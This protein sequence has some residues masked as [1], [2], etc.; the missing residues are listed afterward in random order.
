M[1]IDGEPDSLNSV[2]TNRVDNIRNRLARLVK[3]SN[4]I[5]NK[6]KI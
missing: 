1:L 3:E 2:S 4:N 5:Y 6:S